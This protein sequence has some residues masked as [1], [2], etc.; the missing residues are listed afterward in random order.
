MNGVAVKADK[1]SAHEKKFKHKDGSSSSI[2]LN[3]PGYEAGVGTV[4]IWIDGGIGFKKGVTVANVEVQHEDALGNGGGLSVGVSA[5]LWGRDTAF[6]NAEGDGVTR[7]SGNLGFISGIL[8]F[9]IQKQ[10]SC[11]H[12]KTHIICYISKKKYYIRQARC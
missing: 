11:P 2:S 1:F 12:T 9:L 10:Q 3:G 5:E 4:Y 8:V 6:Q 7:I